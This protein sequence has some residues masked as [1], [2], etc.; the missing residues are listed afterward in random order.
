[1]TTKT[2][3]FAGI[4]E[5]STDRKTADGRPIFELDAGTIPVV[6]TGTHLRDGKA[7]SSTECSFAL[8][9][10]PMPGVT[11]VHVW[12]QRVYI[13]FPDR[14]L[15]AALPKAGTAVVVLNDLSAGKLAKPGSYTLVP[16]AKSERFAGK[17]IKNQRAKAAGYKTKR[18]SMATQH[19]PTGDYLTVAGVRNGVGQVHTQKA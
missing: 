10:L 7:N 14:Q 16:I 13:D 1:M 8:A 15:R 19:S 17:R 2:D 4:T 6:L 9:I 11:G 3:P 12:R 5:A 18:G